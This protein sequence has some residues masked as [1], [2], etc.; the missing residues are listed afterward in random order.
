MLSSASR[1]THVIAHARPEDE[2]VMGLSDI[3]QLIGD[4]AV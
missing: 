3:A 1:K 2:I 4:D